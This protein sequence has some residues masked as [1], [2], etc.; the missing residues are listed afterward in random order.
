MKIR[1]I[2]WTRDRVDH[3][4]KHRIMPHEVEEAA[5]DDPFSIVKKVG[6]SIRNRNEYIYRLLG[7]SE[8]G[9][10]IAFFFIPKNNGIA[11][12]V[13]AREMDQSER[14]FYNLVRSKKS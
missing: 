7:K 3:I 4:A 8:A 13:T 10:Y 11:Y 5:F 1:K 6:I 12:P 2:R 14:R 9:K